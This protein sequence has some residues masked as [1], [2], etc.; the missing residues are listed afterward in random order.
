MTLYMQDTHKVIGKFKECK[1]S[2]GSG[3]NLFA[4]LL[5]NH[6]TVW[7]AVKHC[8]FNYGD[9]G[10]NREMVREHDML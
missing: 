9:P 3:R 6:V 8:S 5:Q 4:V 10:N 7:H 1:M 2:H